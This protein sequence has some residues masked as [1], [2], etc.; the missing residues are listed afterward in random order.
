MEISHIVLSLVA[1]LSAIVF[2]EYA[3]GYV[4]FRLGDPTARAQGR[5][6][7]NPLAHIDPIG[8]VLVPI[9]LVL[10]RMPVFG[11]AKP[12]PVSP[13]YFRNPYQG[14]FYVAIAGPLTNVGLALATTIVGR[15]LLA[16]FPVT[17]GLWLTHA[18][19]YLL[20]IFVLI[21]LL[22]A[23]FNM[24]PIPPLDGSRILAYLLPPEG[25]RFLAV[26]EQYGFL[27]VLAL[28]W[29]GGLR[30][31]FPAVQNVWFELIGETWWIIMV[32]L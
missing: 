27:I 26:F 10:L 13:M 16:L 25:R 7:F 29:L 4:A 11:W 1:V 17:H 19:F 2:H 20:G 30:L 15:F 12:V 3:H 18:F 22:L 5:L 32:R 24:I 21:N 9:V 23:L 14:M 6:T 28:F 8:T 31:V